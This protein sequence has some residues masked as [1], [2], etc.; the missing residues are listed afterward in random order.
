MADDPN[1]FPFRANESIPVLEDP[2]EEEKA[3][4]Q[5]HSNNLYIHQ[6]Q[7]DEVISGPDG[8]LAVY[9]ENKYVDDIKHP[10]LLEPLFFD[11]EWGN[12]DIHI[13]FGTRWERNFVLN[14]LR[15]NS[16]P[17]RS[18]A[19]NGPWIYTDNWCRLDS[20]W[21]NPQHRESHQIWGDA[22]IRYR[23]WQRPNIC[24]RC[25][26]NQLERYIEHHQGAFNRELNDFV[27]E[28]YQHLN[29]AG[30]SI[31]EWEEWKLKQIRK[32]RGQALRG[33]TPQLRATYE[34]RAGPRGSRGPRPT[35][36]T[37]G[38]RFVDKGG[39]GHIW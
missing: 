19:W 5:P 24:A 31:A 14:D 10:S 28:F 12:E 3:V 22:N 23:H 32:A 2:E 26:Y 25:I 33:N 17:S 9:S 29:E 34:E 8:D 13:G 18:S 20:H 38:I 21:H 37:R 6:F 27:D 16:V 11:D 4:Q 15:H 35:T 1:W 30:F 36:W 7:P 39:W